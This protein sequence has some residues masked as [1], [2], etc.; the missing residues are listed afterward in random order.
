LNAFQSN[1]LNTKPLI[2]IIV[3]VYNGG[4]YLEEAINSVV[5]QTFTNFEFIIVDGGSKDNTVDILKKY[6]NQITYWE[7]KPDKGIYDAWNKALQFARGEWICFIGADDYFWRPDALARIVPYLQLSLAQ[8]HRLVYGQIAQVTRASG[9]VIEYLGENWNQAKRKFA[10]RMTLAHCGA[11][12]HRS[13]FQDLGG[14]DVSFKIA[15]DYDFLLREFVRNPD[16][17]IYQPELLISMRTGGVSGDLNLRLVMANEIALARRKN[18]ITSFSL[19]IFLWKLRI[20]VFLML[21][22][23]FGNRISVLLAD[24]YR[25]MSGKEKRW[26]K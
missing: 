3:A 23:L 4:E 22:R 5:N 6:N 7:S 10:K 12:H 19:D 16:F 11:F 2:S 18:N 21:N 26:S 20:K 25:A 13:L 9:E 14:F 1:R 17:A 24:V 8:G 15:G